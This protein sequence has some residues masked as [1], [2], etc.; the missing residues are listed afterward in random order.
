ML[1]DFLL[2]TFTAILL[3]GTI[4]TIH[5]ASSQYEEDNK[6]KGQYERLRGRLDIAFV[7]IPFVLAVFYI[8]LIFRE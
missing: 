8:Y 6:R 2:G 5:W 7:L 3:M 4:G 1:A